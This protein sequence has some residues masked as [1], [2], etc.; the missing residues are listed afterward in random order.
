MPDAA[1]AL[2]KS[3]AKIREMFAGVAP[4]Y[5]FLN[6]LLSAHLDSWWRRRAAA[7]VVARHNDLILDLCCGTGDQAVAIRR[8]GGR[9]VAA[10]FCL[11]MLALAR[12]KLGSGAGISP[13]LAT[14][15]ALALPFA[16]GSFE[17]ATVSFG[18][19]NVQDLDA[20]L[21]E[22]YR[23]L[24]P[25]GQLAV[26]EPAVPK[27]PL[28]RGPYMVYFRHILPRIGALLSP[29]GSAYSYLQESVEAFP[30]REAFAVRL[31]QAGF[32]TATWNDLTAGTVCLYTGRK[33]L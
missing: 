26:L 22:L 19:R 15:D 1:R 6:R 9:V 18:L 2:D 14:A 33:G 21:R 4:R 31:K 16:D 10:D 7:A 17:G 5:D 28:V 27:S 20:A 12:P 30:Q 8:R 13:R 23:V 25:G 32:A 3:P 24:K 11:P 29:R